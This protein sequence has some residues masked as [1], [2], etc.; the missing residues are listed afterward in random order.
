MTVLLSIAGLLFLSKSG[1]RKR[2]TNTPLCAHPQQKLYPSGEMRSIHSR[3]FS[4][5][6]NRKRKGTP[7]P[8]RPIHHFIIKNGSDPSYSA[9]SAFVHRLPVLCSFY[10]IV[11]ELGYLSVA[12]VS[13]STAFT[14]LKAICST[15]G[16]G[17][18]RFSF[19]TVSGRGIDLTERPSA[20]SALIL[21]PTV[22]RT[23]WQHKPLR[24]ILRFMSTGGLCFSR[25]DARGTRKCCKKDHSS[26]NSSKNSTF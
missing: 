24:N 23:C 18:K 11:A 17:N 6:F 5:H 21:P 12:G 14:V 26:S 2:S 25:S 8:G 16:A 7:F 9:S 1:Q 10:I 20:E 19:Q 13:A 3:L 22:F 4:S 15:G